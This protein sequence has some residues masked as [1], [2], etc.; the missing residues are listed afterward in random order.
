MA[1]WVLVAWTSYAAN[2]ADFFAPRSAIDAIAALSGF[3][4]FSLLV[5]YVAGILPAAITGVICH[6]FAQTVRHDLAWVGLCIAVGAG[7]SA[8][9]S[10]A[11]TRAPLI[12]GGFLTLP[13][14]VAAAVCALALRRT[15][16]R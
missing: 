7:V 16:W 13:G 12:E 10:F 2:G 9:A 6:F 3:L 15:R 8:A 5:G 4:L 1:M 14:A 11:L